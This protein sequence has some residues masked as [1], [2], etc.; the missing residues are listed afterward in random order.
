MNTLCTF[1]RREKEGTESYAD[2]EADLGA[3]RIYGEES[4]D[5]V[6]LWLK[7]DAEYESDGPQEEYRPWHWPAAEARL[8]RRKRKWEY[9]VWGVKKTMRQR[10]SRNY[11]R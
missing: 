6:D 2:H 8:T 9:V 11:A 3:G 4:R 5:G 7:E 1:E 10:M